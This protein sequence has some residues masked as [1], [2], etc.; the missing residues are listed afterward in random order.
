MRWFRPAGWIYLPISFIGWLL[1][2]GV[3][4][5]IIWVGVVADRHSHSV[6]DTLINTFPYAAI[7]VLILGW[8]AR[9][10]GGERR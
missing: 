1:T 2:A 3:L 9:H 6:S 4:S 7:L 8:V 10:T 5:L